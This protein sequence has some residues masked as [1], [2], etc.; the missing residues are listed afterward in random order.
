MAN[1]P[2]G[3]LRD[4]LA[5]AFLLLLIWV[6]LLVPVRGADD[7]PESFTVGSTSTFPW[8]HRDSGFLFPGKVAGFVRGDANQYDRSG[9]D[10]SVGY[11]FHHPQVVATFYVYPSEGQTLSEE[12]ARR[13]EELTSKYPQAK[14]VTTGTTDVSPGRHAAL[15][16]TYAI[17]EMFDQKDEPMKS[18]LLVGELGKELIEYRISYPVS[19]GD[20]AEKAAQA[21]LAQFP[22]P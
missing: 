3:R 14:L 9:R 16:A 18:L 2:S 8:V 7:I 17:P 22:W 13:Q 6:S 11:Y 10:V 12:L 4:G 19:G 5:P 20:A 1:I 21:F 15:I